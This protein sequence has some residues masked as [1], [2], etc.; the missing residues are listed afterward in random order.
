MQVLAEEKL[1]VTLMNKLPSFVNGILI[2]CIY[3]GALYVV[4]PCA[5]ASA[6]KHQFTGTGQVQPI[7]GIYISQAPHYKYFYFLT[8]DKKY[9]YIQNQKKRL[10]NQFAHDQYTR[11]YTITAFMLWVQLSGN[12][13][14]CSCGAVLSVGPI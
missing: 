3:S 12:F 5:T 13:Q 2:L 14:N 6:L 8:V 7:I 9:T 1:Q 4:G 10:A 11:G